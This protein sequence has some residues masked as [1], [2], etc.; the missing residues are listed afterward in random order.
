M[1]S[2]RNTIA[3]VLLATASATALA[4]TT[5]VVPPQPGAPTAG[6]AL[7]TGANGP[8]FV[9]VWDPVKSFSLVQYLGLGYNDVSIPVM[10]DTDFLNFGTLATFSSTF[11]EA[12]AGGVTSRLQ[13]MVISVDSDTTDGVAGA[14]VRATGA[15]GFNSSVLAYDPAGFSL[16]VQGAIKGWVNDVWN[17][18]G[19]AATQC[20][21]INPCV[22][23][24]GDF[25][26]QKFW[27]NLPGAD[28]G[29]SIPASTSFAG[30]V[31]TALSFFETT[32]ALA[33]GGEPELGPYTMTSVVATGAGNQWLLSADGRLT[34]GAEAVDPIPLPAAAWLLLSGLAGLG[35]VA[36]RRQ[37]A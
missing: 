2:L 23:T 28:F 15:P 6:P 1:N 3:C 5:P 16:G 37:A 34:Y 7:T 10:S 12:I 32:I 29:G 19:D 31:G 18:V 36:R 14:G 22:Y 17:T 13:Y 25:N 11:A 30:N 24:G 26:S 20:L 35:A 8:L 9:A 27:G 4:D 21:R 33:P